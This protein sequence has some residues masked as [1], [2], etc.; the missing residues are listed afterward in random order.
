MP[1]TTIGQSGLLF[2]VSA[3]AGVGLVQSFTETRN[4]DKVEARNQTGDVVGLSYYN[5]TTAYA[6]S[7]AV[8]GNYTQVA[9]TILTTLANALTAGS[10]KIVID[11]VTVNK[12]NDAF[13]TV[14]IAATGYPSLAA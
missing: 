3:E 1:A 2:G 10:N 4:S 14:D 11:S 7:V 8:T 12:S 6:L 13:V 9:G 5:P